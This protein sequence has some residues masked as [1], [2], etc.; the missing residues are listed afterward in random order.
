MGPSL[1]C[2]YKL[3]LYESQGSRLGFSGNFAKRPQESVSKKLGFE[4]SGSE[5]SCLFLQELQNW[6]SDSL[7]RK[8][9]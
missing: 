5:E 4:L 7:E 6:P 2:W 9:P 8:I 3:G 1:V